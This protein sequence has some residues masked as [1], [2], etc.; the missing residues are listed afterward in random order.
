MHMII[1]SLFPVLKTTYRSGRRQLLGIGNFHDQSGARSFI[2]YDISI[3]A[4][5]VQRSSCM[6][7][8][9]RHRGW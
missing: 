3:F 4:P 5:T 9:E 8:I 6:F 7:L 2:F 1:K